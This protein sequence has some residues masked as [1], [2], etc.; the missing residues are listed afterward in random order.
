MLGK[1]TTEHVNAIYVFP[2]IWCLGMCITI[3][4]N[5]HVNTL[6]ELKSYVNIRYTVCIISAYN[7]LVSLPEGD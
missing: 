3:F 7:S 4:R 6:A 5:M 1:L 2:N